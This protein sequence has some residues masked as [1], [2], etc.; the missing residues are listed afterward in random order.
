LGRGS[1]E[2][3]R[4]RVVLLWWE[5]IG[6]ASADYIHRCHIWEKVA[7]LFT[8]SGKKARFFNRGG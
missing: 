4:E 8:K 5:I 1:E 7:R 6:E 3:S 2:P